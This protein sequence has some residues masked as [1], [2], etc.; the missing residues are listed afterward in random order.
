MMDFSSADADLGSIRRVLSQVYPTGA[1]EDLTPDVL[2]VHLDNERL[3]ALLGSVARVD[4]LTVVF[5]P[6][7]VKSHCL[8]VG[9]AGAPDWEAFNR[10]LSLRQ[11]VSAVAERN[12]QIVYWNILLSRLGPFWTDYW[13]TFEVRKNQAVPSL[14]EPS[15]TPE[16]T[17]VRSNVRRVLGSFGLRRV[18]RELSSLR[19]EWLAHH[20]DPRSSG[21]RPTVFDALFSEMF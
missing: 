12:G 15:T 7:L 18:G 3:D 14:T 2:D 8:H 1:L 16:W 11:R 13:N 9:V 21:P 20:G 17:A 4:G 19:T 6:E 5:E 10:E